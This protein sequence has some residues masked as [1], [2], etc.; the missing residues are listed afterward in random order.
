MCLE[1]EHVI[2]PRVRKDDRIISK[3]DRITIVDETRRLYK[4][5]VQYREVCISIYVFKKCAFDPSVEKQLAEYLVNCSRI[6]NITPRQGQRDSS[7]AEIGVAIQT[8]VSYVAKYTFALLIER[9]STMEQR[10]AKRNASQIQDVATK[11]FIYTSETKPADIP[12]D[13]L[14][15]LRVAPSWKRFLHAPFVPAKHCTFQKLETF[16]SDR[17]LE[18]G[19]IVFAFSQCYNLQKLP[20][21]LRS[22][23]RAAFR[24]CFSLVQVQLP[25][26]LTYIGTYAFC[27]CANLKL[28]QFVS[29]ASL[30]TSSSYCSL[31]DGTIVLP[32]RVKQIDRFAFC[33]CDSLRKVVVCSTSTNL[34][35]GAFSSC[36]GLLSVEL[37][38]DLQDHIVQYMDS[39]G[40][41]PMD[42]LC[43]NRMPNSTEAIRRVLQMCFDYSLGLESLCKSDALCQA[44]DKA[45]AVD[46]SS[47]R[48]AIGRVYF[49]LANNEWKEVFCLLELFLWKVKIDGFGLKKKEQIADRQSCRISCGA[50]IVIPYVIT[51][52]GNSSRK[53]IFVDSP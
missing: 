29:D 51:F 36:R 40:S 6:N 21:G 22:I 16:S 24:S 13:T 49:E 15:H 31:E 48:R 46:L 50:S 23:P 33:F 3:L 44:V 1:Q 28:V 8:V 11:W 53:T 20:E 39:F 32:D 30:E 52:L 34:G 27:R 2:P 42:Y 35:K 17:S 7:C 19:T 14:T 41:T 38:E 9:P 10:N 45:L 37:P 25:E 26:T 18:D 12:N 5:L 4:K 47:R 43:L